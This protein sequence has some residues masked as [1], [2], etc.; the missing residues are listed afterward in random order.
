MNFRHTYIYALCLVLASCA[1]TSTAVHKYEP[2]EESVQ[3]SYFAAQN[4][5]VKGDLDMAY[6]SLQTCA[7]AEPEMASFH[8]ELGKIDYELGRHDAAV[9][10]L[11]KAVLLDPKNDWYSYYRGIS[12]LELEN[13]DDAWSDLAYWVQQRPSDIGSLMAC[14]SMFM[15]LQQPMHALKMLFFYEGEIAKN[16]DV[17]LMELSIMVGYGLA[18]VEG[19]EEF[20]KDAISD[21]PETPEFYYEEAMIS[22]F[23]E[24]YDLA[25]KQFEKVIAEYPSYSQAKLSLGEC[26]WAK[27][28]LEKAL[29]ILEGAFKSYDIESGDK[30]RVLFEIQNAEFEGHIT[31]KDLEPLVL[32]AVNIHPNDAD[33]MFYA[34]MYFVDSQQFE[35]AEKAYLSVIEMAPKKMAAHLNLIDLYYDQKQG[36]KVLET[37]EKALDMFPLESRLY[38]YT[39]EIYKNKKE[40]AKSVKELKKGVAVLIDLPELE[41]LFYAEL[42]HNYRELGELDKSYEMFEKSLLK[43]EDP[44]VMNNHAFF[45][46]KDGVMVEKAYNWSM[47]S[48]ELI[49]NDPHFLDTLALILYIKG[50]Y[51]KALE[52]IQKAQN[53]ILPKTDDV[54]NRREAAIL[55]ELGR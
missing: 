11:N 38:L 54:Y 15:E 35:K 31:I 13:F 23:K 33:L 22:Y 30:L 49:P 24:N 55:K 48:N 53:L 8:Y 7:T 20:L 28:D 37:A 10:N 12:L 14:S 34:A 50:D 39:A 3:R 32:N 1:G 42:G 44:L 18:D 9:T 52:M 4:H 51:E 2:L 21:F 41:A 40:Y 5:L 26:V 45:L 16:L 43:F 47:L 19:I 36:D 6:S 27:G 29:V 25:I 46:A 17:R